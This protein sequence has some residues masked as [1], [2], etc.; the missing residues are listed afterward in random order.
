MR[1][2]RSRWRPGCA[3]TTLT[4]E[5]AAAQRRCSSWAKSRLACSALR[6]DLP[7]VIRRRVQELRAGRTCR[8][9]CPSRAS[10]LDTSTT[11]PG[12]SACNRLPQPGDQRGVPEMVSGSPSAVRSPAPRAP[13]VRPSHP[14]CRPALGHAVTTLEQC[15]WR[16]GHGDLGRYRRGRTRRCSSTPSVPAKAGRGLLTL[17]EIAHRQ[18]D[19]RAV[20][21]PG[22]RLR[23]R[24]DWR[25]SP[26][27][28]PR[29][30]AEPWVPS[31]CG[32]ER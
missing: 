13:T 16:H 17:G 9:S 28:A 11:A 21:R 3:A 14:R 15:G 30:L 26:L 24:A 10:V 4:G 32:V 20:A 23:A 5:P 27:P 31:P 2:G 6:I 19:V 7:A 25:L 22:A 29:L 1:R 12:G 8:D 18:D